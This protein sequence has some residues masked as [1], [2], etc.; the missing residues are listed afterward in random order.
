[1]S[2]NFTCPA[3]GAEFSV[4]ER[5]D[6]DAEGRRRSD[7]GADLQREATVACPNCGTD[8]KRPPMDRP[9]ADPA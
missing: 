5:L 4:R 2:E 6:E 7:T 3:C 1:M 8:V 9:P